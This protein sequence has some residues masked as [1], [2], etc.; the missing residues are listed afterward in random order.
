[1]NLTG[2]SHQKETAH[3]NNTFFTPVKF[4]FL[5]QRF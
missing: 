5:M 4:G 1:M 3:E 2:V